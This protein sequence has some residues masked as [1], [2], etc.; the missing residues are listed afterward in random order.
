MMASPSASSTTL[1]IH[2]EDNHLGP[3]GDEGDACITLD[4]EEDAIV[5]GLALQSWE[6][7][8][9]VYDDHD[10]SFVISDD[11]YR[12]APG[13]S[14]SAPMRAASHPDPRV[15]KTVLNHANDMYWSRVEMDL[16]QRQGNGISS[17]NFASLGATGSRQFADVSQEFGPNSIRVN[18]S[19][20]IGIT[21]P[22]L[23][24]ISAGTWRT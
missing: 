1:S 7:E 10:N 13:W 23:E 20:D 9:I 19:E 22:L 24:A 2:P 17:P 3:D 11:Y 16:E 8:G 21:T 12:P 15:L 6:V 5:D 4:K 14:L 18:G